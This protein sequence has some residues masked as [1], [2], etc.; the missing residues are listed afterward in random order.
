[1]NVSDVKGI[2][3]F[4]AL[5]ILRVEANQ[6][7]SLDVT[8]NP[9]LEKLLCASNNITALDVSQAY[10]LLCSVFILTHK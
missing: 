6:L 4:P 2:E 7:T 10:N 5:E 8:K 3:H 9:V 1:M